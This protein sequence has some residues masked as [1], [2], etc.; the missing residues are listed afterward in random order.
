MSEEKT[1][2]I[3]DS[4]DNRQTLIEKFRKNC[5]LLGATG[6]YTYQIPELLELLDDE[7]LIEQIAGQGRMFAWQEEVRKSNEASSYNHKRKRPR[8][9]RNDD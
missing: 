5:E 6:A 8:L 9:K 1:L 2:A 7:G 4:N 3:V